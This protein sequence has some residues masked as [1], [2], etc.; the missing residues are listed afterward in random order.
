[1]TDR[2]V[3]L[4][5]DWCGVLTTPVQLSFDSWMVREEIDPQGFSTAMPA[6]H[7]EA[8]S[9]LHRV[10]R[11]EAR[12]EEFERSLAASLWTLAG[13]EAEPDGLLDRLFADVGCNDAMREV[14]RAA[15]AGGIPTA[16]LP[17]S[18]GMDYDEDDLLDVAGTLLL[19]GRMG[20]RK[21]E[22]LAYVRASQSLSVDPAN[23]VSVDDLGRNAR[24]ARDASMMS[25]VYEPG[26][27]A[28]VIDILTSRFGHNFWEQR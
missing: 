8:D 25:I 22:L 2:S 12:R 17:K 4:I 21:P 1:M 6:L 15:R 23:C 20:V 16:I 11:G 24:G 19:S 18:W 7:D 10:E 27:K 5:V 3:A 13:G 9:P 14:V 28:S 26:V